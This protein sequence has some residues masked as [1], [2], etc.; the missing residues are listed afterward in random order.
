MRQ[1]IKFPQNV[2]N[3]YDLIFESTF[4]VLQTKGLNYELNPTEGRETTPAAHDE[5]TPLVT[6][7]W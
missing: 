1:I 3:K 5:R 6:T 4:G 7:Y 2:R